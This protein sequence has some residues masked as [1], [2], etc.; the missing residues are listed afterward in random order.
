MM[1]E[2]FILFC[3]DIIKV[4]GKREPDSSWLHIMGEQEAMDTTQGT[5]H[6]NEMQGSYLF[7]NSG[8]DFPE[9]LWNLQP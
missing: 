5:G 3:N 8:T 6:S 9:R 4:E 1:R 2:N 7:S